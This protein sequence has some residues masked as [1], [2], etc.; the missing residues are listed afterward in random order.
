MAKKNEENSNRPL[1]EGAL[2]LDFIICDNSVNRYKWRLLVSGIDTEGFMKN[3]VCCVQHNTWTVPIGK[4]LKIWVEGEQL[5]GTLEFDRNDDNAVMYYYKYV[6]GYMSAVSLNIIPLEESDDTNLMLPGQRY[7]TITK[8]ELLEVSVVTVPGQ[9]NAVK[10]STQEG[11]SYKLNLLTN[12]SN[13]KNMA[14]EE[15]TVEQLNKELSALKQ[16]NADMLVSMH[17]NR[18]VVV[19]SEVD[20]LK[21]L[22]LDNFDDIKQMLEARLPI[23]ADETKTDAKQLAVALVELHSQRV[24]LSVD[25]KNMYTSAAT[26]DYEG[27]KKALEARKG[28]DN[29]ES[30]VAGM[31][32]GKSQNERADWTYLDYYKKDPEALSLMQKNDPDKFK[33]LEADFVEESRKM[34]IA[35]T[36]E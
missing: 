23:T 32:V 12:N 9:K 1:P 4:W 6:D 35:S 13:Q 18:G 21:K 27:T 16:L 24:G 34:G 10:L 11:K 30:F 19:D 2:T 36:N 14:K 8:S 22:A 28:K 29:V 33:K 15:K 17:K 25:E 31:G 5:K 26:L 20:T 3:P 7:G